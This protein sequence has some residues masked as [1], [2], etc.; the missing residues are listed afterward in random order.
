MFGD[1]LSKFV[2]DMRHTPLFSLSDNLIGNIP[3][4]G[5]SVYAVEMGQYGSADI[6]F[7]NYSSLFAICRVVLKVCFSFASLRIVMN[8]R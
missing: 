2:N 1:R 3:S 4:G 7:S 8:K 5:S 6:D